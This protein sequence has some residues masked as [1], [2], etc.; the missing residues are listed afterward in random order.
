M[1]SVL[2][3]LEKNTNISTSPL[4]NYLYIIRTGNK[5]T[6][7]LGKTINDIYVDY[8]LVLNLGS[9]VS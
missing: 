8:E 7:N 6:Y 9:A 4:H 5:L 3:I 1:L 2:I